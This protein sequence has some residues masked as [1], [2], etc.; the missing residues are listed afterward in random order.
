MKINR[1]ELPKYL[2]V[3]LALFAVFLTVFFYLK[4]SADRGKGQIFESENSVR[5]KAGV[6]EKPVNYAVFRRD[7]YN[8]SIKHPDELI[9]REYGGGGGFVD[10][11]R[12]EEVGAGSFKG[13]AIGVSKTPLTDE[14]KRIKE[15]FNKQGALLA[16]ES[17]FEFRGLP[18]YRLYY[19]A[20]REGEENRMVVIFRNG[21]YTYSI[22]CVPE[23]IDMVLEW[24]SFLQ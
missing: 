6:K 4:K 12:F 13:F 15:L 7:L 10:F 3:C 8:Y 1:R 14:V 18:A 19:K 11:V 23:Q 22:S 24:F 17:A 21:Q 2:L 5:E 16:E 20:E 9:L